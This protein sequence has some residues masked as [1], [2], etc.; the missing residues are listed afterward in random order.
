MKAD[1]L[2]DI[3]QHITSKTVGCA[4]E[5]PRANGS[6]RYVAKNRRIIIEPTDLDEFL[7]KACKRWNTEVPSGGPL[8]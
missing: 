6:G 8:L 3:R 5:N 2:L 7:R 4:V 1:C